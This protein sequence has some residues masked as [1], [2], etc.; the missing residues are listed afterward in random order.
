M[1]GL[2]DHNVSTRAQWLQRFT[3]NSKHT[4]TFYHTAPERLYNTNYF[5]LTP[6]DLSFLF[7]V[8]VCLCTLCVA[9][10]CQAPEDPEGIITTF[11]DQF[12]ISNC[13]STF[14]NSCLFQ[15]RKSFSKKVSGIIGWGAGVGGGGEVGFKKSLFFDAL[16]VF[17][18]LYCISFP[19]RAYSIRLTQSSLSCIFPFEDVLTHRLTTYQHV[20][21]QHS[22]EHIDTSTPIH[23][24]NVSTSTCSLQLQSANALTKVN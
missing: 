7:C 15:E 2:S 8:R 20:I 11:R 16:T 24:Q 5:D 14:L 22:H 23:H 3:K 18:I 9:P 19:S 4:V 21:Q 17:A 12:S 1:N 6:K 10:V 13:T